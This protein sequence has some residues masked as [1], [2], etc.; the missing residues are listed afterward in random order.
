LPW[1]AKPARVVEGA[2]SN[3]PMGAQ[4]AVFGTA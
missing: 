1:E 2:L 4:Y 3:V